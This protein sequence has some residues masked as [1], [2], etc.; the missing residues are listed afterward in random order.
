[1]PGMTWSPDSQRIALIDCTYNWKANHPGSLSGGDGV[2][3]SRRCSLAVV[4]ATPSEHAT[5]LEGVVLDQPGGV[6]SGA[7]VRL[8]SLER[9]RETKTDDRGRFEFAD[10]PSGSYDLQVE[11]PGF[12]TGTVE[13]I[14]V[15]DRVIQQFSITL[16][17]VNPTCDFK[18]TVNFGSRPDKVN[19]KGSVNDV[20]HGPLKDARLT[21]TSSES[22]LIHVTS[23]NDKGEFQF[24]DL[25][26]G[27]YALRVTHDGYWDGSATDVR[28][29]RENLTVLG[30]ISIL[31]KN[32]HQTII[33]Q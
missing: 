17:I 16:Q 24:I 7:S 3:S 25:E 10:I 32:E 12:K 26:P 31:R 8:F 21:L 2:E 11:H 9:I 20:W 23:S 33:C 13:S 14:Q 28:I 27:K 15:T 22:G 5:R 4:P 1:M 30:P 19:L 18:P 6:I 29:A